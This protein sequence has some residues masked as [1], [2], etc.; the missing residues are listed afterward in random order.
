MSRK[1]VTALHQDN[2]FNELRTR[3]IVEVDNHSD[4]A[5]EADISPSTIHNWVHGKT[6]HPRID[7]LTK[8]ATAM[9]YSFAIHRP[10]PKRKRKAA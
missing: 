8:V 9:G 3:I 2:L 6:L 7:T 5:Q 4:L 10:T 1:K